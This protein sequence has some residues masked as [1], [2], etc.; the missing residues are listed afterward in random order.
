LIE[1][2]IESLEAAG[3]LFH[4]HKIH[5]WCVVEETCQPLGSSV[6]ASATWDYCSS[7]RAMHL[8]FATPAI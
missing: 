4:G 5:D 7:F 1:G 8:A 3:V 6:K 2:A